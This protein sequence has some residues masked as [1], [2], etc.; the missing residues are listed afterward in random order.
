LQKT[1]TA[2]EE[3]AYKEASSPEKVAP[4]REIFRLFLPLTMASFANAFIPPFINAGI[5]R[6]AD[7]IESSLAAYSVASNLTWLLSPFAVMVPNVY[8]VLVKNRQSFSKLRSF[9]LL[10]CGGVIGAGS[11]LSFTP[12]ADVVLGR[13]I[14]LTPDLALRATGTLRALLLLPLVSIWR[15]FSQ[16]LLISRHRADIVWWGSLAGFLAVIAGVGVSRYLSFLPGD[17]FGALMALTAACVEAGVLQWGASRPYIGSFSDPADGEGSY[18]LTYPDILRFFMP[19]VLTTWIMGLSPTVLNSGLARTPNPEVSIA[20]FSVATSL[21]FAFESPVMVIRNL[22][23][24]LRETSQ[25]MRRLRT[26]SLL[27]GVAMTSIVAL[28]G[29]TKLAEI[30][31]V[32]L[33]GVSREV[34]NLSLPVVRILSLSLVILAWR[35]F[36]YA[37]LMRN[38]KTRYIGHSAVAR[39]LFLTAA[40]FGGMAMWPTLPGTH[41]A[42]IAYIGG[43]IVETLIVYGCGFNLVPAKR[44][45]LAEFSRLK[46]DRS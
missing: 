43:F 35:Q 7:D 14:G 15:A 18:K 36:Y 4:W 16:G 39:L 33:T 31:L 28:I 32:G 38:L 29:F 11:L 37:L 25:T 30:T 19:L 9:I 23:L 22:A 2:V 44:P 46:R 3:P 40:L 34:Y 21:T 42:A 13:V 20:A 17:I 8:L 26:F 27:V 45:P 10:L 5:V 41:I 24:S 1:K 6:V 12:I